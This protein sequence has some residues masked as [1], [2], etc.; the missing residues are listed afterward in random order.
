MIINLLWYKILKDFV[1][2]IFEQLCLW[3]VKICY[4][5]LRTMSKLEQLFVFG[6]LFM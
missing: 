3:I 4:F 2:G 5:Q 1:S 6:K